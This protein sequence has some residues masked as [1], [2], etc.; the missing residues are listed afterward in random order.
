L[1]VGAA[2]V[3][4]TVRRAIPEDAE[5]LVALQREVQDLH[6]QSR[7]DQFKATT[8]DV[9]ARW[10]GRLLESA[11]TQVWVA[12][13]AGN[14]VGNAVAMQKHR[15]EHTFSPAR[16]WCEVD[17]IVVTQAHR[18]QGIARALLQAIVRDAHAKGIVEIELSSWSFNTE[19]HRAFEAFGFVPKLVRFELRPR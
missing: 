15:A 19:A 6:L 17:Q 3:T 13:S 9:V 18:R 10:F 1:S 4:I 8:D 14:V 16:A 5:A 7:P 2:R 12:L 11:D